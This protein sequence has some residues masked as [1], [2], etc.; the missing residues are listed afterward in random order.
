M[1]EKLKME[2]L[3]IHDQN[4][5]FIA[6]K[7]PNAVVETVEE[8][9]VVRK[10]DFAVL[11]QELSSVLIGENQDRYQMVWPKKRESILIANSSTTLT[12]RPKTEG[13][14]SK[15]IF[16]EGD[17]L[18]ALRI[19]RETYL[20]KVK[21]IYI[22]PPY[23]TGEDFVYRD[24]S[25]S[26]I[27]KYLQESGQIDESQNRMVQNPESDG[28]FHTNWLNMIYPRLKVAKDFLTEDGLIFISIDY[29]EVSNLRKICDEIFGQS[30]FVGEII[31]QTATDNN[32]S[33]I[34][35]EH[36][37]IECYAKNIAV[38]SNWSI[39]SQKA[40]LIQE[41][42]ALLKEQLKEPIFIQRELKRWIKKNEDK[43]S[44][45]AHYCYV[46]DRG[47]Y[48]PGNSSNTKPGGYMYDIIHPV[49]KKPCKKPEYGW[50]WPEKTFWDAEAVGDVD[51]GD[52]ETTIPHIK[53]RLETATE[54]LK[55]YYYEDNRYWTKYVNDLLGPKVFDNPKSVNL[56]KHL[57]QFVTK[58]DDI[59]MDFFAGSGSTG[60]AVMSLNHDDGQHRRFIL[61]QI[62]ELCNPK[63][64]AAKAGYHDIAEICRKRL[65]LVG[66]KYTGDTKYRYFVVDSSNMKDVYYNPQKSQQSL[67]ENDV[68]NIK[69]DR[70]PLDLLFQVMLDLGADLS[71]SIEQSIVNG[72]TIYCVDNNYLLA[73]FASRVDED[74]IRI[75]AG[76]K[77]VYAV[78]RDSCFA[79]DSASINCE[80]L[81]K[82]I[83]PST[84]LKVL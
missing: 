38:Q 65:D 32:P 27:E 63:S 14:E 78:F 77:P 69:E 64:A 72:K 61:I 45:V 31:W 29:H 24:K 71:S 56:L 1:A 17:N 5:D 52:D 37:Y 74:T 9:V 3:N 4:V 42:Y 59:V 8:G 19:L 30:N 75:I 51:W 62:P 67:L 44:G 83:S 13:F 28:R 70:K 81:F 16:I 35:I 33:Q 12:L 50:R 40:S 46:D 53:K 41:Q 66:P 79:V 18:D 2:S 73:C 20:G 23:N 60:E 26:E 80:Q 48:Y 76:M 39:P 54:S 58:E 82:A 25:A 34:S 21:M 11:Q 10:I 68:N 15:N 6:Q 22:D 43:L 84:T 57:M 7:F 36:E 55:S 47:V 49:T